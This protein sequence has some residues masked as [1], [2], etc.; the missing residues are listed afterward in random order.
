MTPL[1]KAINK[2]HAQE[3][4]DFKKKGSCSERTYFSDEVVL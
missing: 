4:K 3:A 1:G 2:V